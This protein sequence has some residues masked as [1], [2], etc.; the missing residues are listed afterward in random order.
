MRKNN[1]Y[2]RKRFLDCRACYLRRA[3]LLFVRRFDFGG[4]LT[5]FPPSAGRRVPPGFF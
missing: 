1:A 2:F 5:H 3:V 4:G